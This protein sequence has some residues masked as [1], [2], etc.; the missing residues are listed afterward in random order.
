MRTSS[1]RRRLSRFLSTAEWPYLGTM[2]PARTSGGVDTSD[3]EGEAAARTSSVPV[4]T[5]FPSFLTR[6]SSDAFVIRCALGKR[7]RGESPVIG[8]PDSGSRDVLARDPDGETLA[9]LLA[10]AAQDITPPSCS[11]AGPEAVRT[12]ALLVTGTI[13]GLAHCSSRKSV[14]L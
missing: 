1:R 5:R 10:A 7:A 9:P 8:A 2:I 4:R 11:H 6:S 14:V 12:D 13:S 3:G